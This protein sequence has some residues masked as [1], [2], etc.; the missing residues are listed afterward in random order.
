[1]LECTA[2][3]FAACVWLGKRSVGRS[4]LVAQLAFLAFAA[5]A[6]HLRQQPPAA[7]SR[8]QAHI[9]RCRQPLLKPQSPELLA[10]LSAIVAATSIDQVNA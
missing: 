6:A 9:E 5:V 3:L 1:M 10:E 8:E 2:R 4:L 7:N